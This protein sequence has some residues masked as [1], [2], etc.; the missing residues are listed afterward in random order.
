MQTIK[1]DYVPPYWYAKSYPA[2][3]KGHNGIK[4]KYVSGTPSVLCHKIDNQ[5]CLYLAERQHLTQPIQQLISLN[6]IGLHSGLF[7]ISK[8]AGLSKIKPTFFTKTPSQ[9]QIPILRDPDE[10]KYLSIRFHQCNWNLGDCFSLYI[11]Q[12]RYPD[13]KLGELKQNPL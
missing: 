3:H 11:F 2:S 1:L 4:S 6:G 10:L 12:I 7:S 8:R 13:Q 9:I 5:T